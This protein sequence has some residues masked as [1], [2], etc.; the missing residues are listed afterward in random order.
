MNERQL[1]PPALAS[2]PIRTYIKPGFF[3]ELI[4]TTAVGSSVLDLEI[5]MTLAT[6]HWR[7]K[8]TFLNF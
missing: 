1:H 2:E 6:D 7:L 3:Y 8:V 4:Y 5:H